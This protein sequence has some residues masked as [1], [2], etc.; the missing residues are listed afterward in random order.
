MKLI[1]KIILVLS[2]V[3]S[4]LL[5]LNIE[6]GKNVNIILFIIYITYFIYLSFSKFTNQSKK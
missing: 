5:F 3:I 1:T 4:F 6:I 2:L